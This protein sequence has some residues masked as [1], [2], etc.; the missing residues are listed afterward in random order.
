MK[1]A[2]LLM[3]MAAVFFTVSIIGARPVQAQS[4][5]SAGCGLG[6]MLFGEQEG[7]IQIFASTTNALFLSQTFGITSGTSNCVD[8]GLVSQNHEQEAFFEMN[9]EA[10]RQDM[11]AGQGEHLMAMGSLLGCSSE[12]QGD[13]AR[14]SQAHYEEIFPSDHTSANQALYSYKM[15]LSQQENFAQSC[16]RL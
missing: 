10:L 1:F 16:A 7:M 3:V 4:Y 8:R 14:F 11:A 9:Y 5:G 2:K 6:A 12:V 15:Q 13:L